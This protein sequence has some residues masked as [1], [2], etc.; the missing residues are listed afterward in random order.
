MAMNVRLILFW[1][2]ESSYF[3]EISYTHTVTFVLLLD[4]VGTHQKSGDSK[5]SLDCL[6][7][8]QTNYKFPSAVKN[9]SNS[10][11]KSAFSNIQLRVQE[12][13]DQLDVLKQSSSSSGSKAFQQVLP[14]IR[15][16]KLSSGSEY[17][18]EGFEDSSSKSNKSLPK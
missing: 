6:L 13:K 12:L 18:D 11:P 15:P 8:Q 1:S 3:L 5:N 9:K 10:L 2:I 14:R 7:E 17:L 16:P 4:L